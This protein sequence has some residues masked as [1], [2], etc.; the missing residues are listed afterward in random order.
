M[1]VSACLST[2]RP[3]LAGVEE[4]YVPKGKFKLDVAQD[5][6]DVFAPRAM[7]ELVFRNIIMNAV[8]HHDRDVGTVRIESIPDERFVVFSVSDDGPGIPAQ[9][10]EKVFQLF[11]TLKA[12]DEVEGSGLGLAL[13][14]KSMDKVNGE[15]SLM[16]SSGRGA[17]F[18]L[19]WPKQ[20]PERNRTAA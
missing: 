19:K 15:V 9:F 7:V 3:L 12:R 8:K 16:P 6:P 17:T 11:Q 5:L 4:L 18:V 2:L 13:V 20:F 1:G 10:R 14:R